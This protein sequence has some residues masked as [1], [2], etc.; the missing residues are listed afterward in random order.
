[1][2]LLHKLLTTTLLCFAAVL[3]VNA[4][5]RPIPPVTNFEV[6]GIFYVV[7]DGG[8]AAKVNPAKRNVLDLKNETC[9]NREK[10]KR[11]K[12]FAHTIL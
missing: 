5:F 8:V 3:H 2:T 4:Q 7:I 9:K 12:N 11:S 1:M 10:T 6:N